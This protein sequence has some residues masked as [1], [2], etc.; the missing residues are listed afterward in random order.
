MVR[1]FQVVLLVKGD[2][3]RRRPLEQKPL[4]A[5]GD[6]GFE[7]RRQLALCLVDVFKLFQLGFIA[8]VDVIQRFLFGHKHIQQ[9]LEAGNGALD[10]I[11]VGAQILYRFQ[12]ERVDADLAFDLFEVAPRNRQALL[13]CFDAQRHTFGCHAVVDTGAFH[14]AQIGVLHAQEV[15]VG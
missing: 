15:A 3:L 10:I 12:L 7:F 11:S 5:I 14:L 6:S 4:F 8:P 13:Q 2:Q 1:G 9:F